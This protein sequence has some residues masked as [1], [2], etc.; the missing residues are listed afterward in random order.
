VLRDYLTLAYSG[1]EGVELPPDEVAWLAKLRALID[2]W[3]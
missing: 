3:R 2:A 1:S